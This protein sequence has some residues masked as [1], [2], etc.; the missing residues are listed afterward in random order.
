MGKFSPV[1][2]KELGIR[3]DK[4]CKNI[5]DKSNLALSRRSGIEGI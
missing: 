2:T 4:I 1:G 5:S 3:K